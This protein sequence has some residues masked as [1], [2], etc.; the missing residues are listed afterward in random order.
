MQKPLKE[1]LIV[2]ILQVG[3]CSK[4]CEKAALS[5]PKRNDTRPRLGYH[6]FECGQLKSFLIG[7]LAS[8][9]ALPSVN[10]SVAVQ[11]AVACLAD[12]HP[13]DV[14]DAIGPYS[15]RNVS[16]CFHKENAYW[17]TSLTGYLKAQCY[18]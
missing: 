4:T 9:F 12:T 2:L 5:P 17:L 13:D 18:H 6:F 3:F 8:A 10:D 16:M 7:D 14:L 11:L 1:N 15:R